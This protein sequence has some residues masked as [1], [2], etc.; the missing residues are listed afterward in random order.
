MK[1]QP[2]D[3]HTADVVFGSTVDLTIELP[4]LAHWSCLSVAATER[5][6]CWWMGKAQGM[7]PRARRAHTHTHIHTLFHMA[8]W[9]LRS[10]LSQGKIRECGKAWETT[11]ECAFLCTLLNWPEDNYGGH[12]LSPQQGGPCVRR[13]QLIAQ[14]PNWAFEG[15]FT[16]QPTVGSWSQPARGRRGLCWHAIIPQLMWGSGRDSEEPLPNTQLGI[17]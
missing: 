1:P 13:A 4:R 8:P 17:Y 14:S 12:R 10:V 16:H 5:S 15:E 6:L 2:S 11:E 3:I 7:L 9:R